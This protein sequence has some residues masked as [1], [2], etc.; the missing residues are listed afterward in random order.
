MRVSPQEQEE[1]GQ[2]GEVDE[3]VMAIVK[4]CSV[5][6]TTSVSKGSCIK[7]DLLK[8]RREILEQG[9]QDDRS[10]LDGGQSRRGGLGMVEGEG[11]TLIP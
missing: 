1:R 7:Y 2:Q 9:R 4:N 10:S 6:T 5:M 11:S 8:R 3:L